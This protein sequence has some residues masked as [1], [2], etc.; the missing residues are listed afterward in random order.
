M[1]LYD[2]SLYLVLACWSPFFGR[3]HVESQDGIELCESLEA[4][5]G[6]LFCVNAAI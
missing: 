3:F 5:L 1:A 4:A 2:G 6:V